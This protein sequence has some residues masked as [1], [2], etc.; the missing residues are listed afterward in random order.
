MAKASTIQPLEYFCCG[1]SLDLGCM[2]ILSIHLLMCLMY[3]FT[4]LSNIVF[5]DPTM[6]ASVA[7]AIQAF[8]C[9]FALAGLPFIASGFSGVKFQHETHLRIY[10]YWLLFTYVL[11]F[12]FVSVDMLQNNCAKIPSFLMHSGGS[13]ACGLMRMVSIGTL[14]VYLVAMGYASFTVWSRCLELQL[15]GSAES[16]GMLL[17]KGR[18]DENYLPPQHREGL[19]GTGPT[20]SQPLPLV[21]GSLAT[22]VFAGSTTIFGGNVHDVSFPPRAS[23]RQEAQ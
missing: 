4:T 13:F 15:G 8:N 18:V 3:I 12:I 17:M 7:P 20:P 19:F 11:D 1:C 6:G 16:L 9:G 14:L 2:V 10:L 22:P 23:R 21:Y 5:E